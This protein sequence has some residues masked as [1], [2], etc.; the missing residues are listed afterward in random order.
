MPA[1]RR[2]NVELRVALVRDGRGQTRLAADAGLSA[3][4]INA[5]LTGRK[6]IS[7][8]S[9]RRIADALGKPQHELFGDQRPLA[10]SA[11]PS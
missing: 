1:P 8:D 9:R 4:T 7:P 3:A 5:A 10:A 6:V 11:S 2:D